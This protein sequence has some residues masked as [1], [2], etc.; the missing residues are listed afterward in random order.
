MNMQAGWLDDLTGWFKGIFQA[1]WNALVDFLHDMVIFV[2]HGVLDLALAIFNAIP[3]PAFITNNGLG[4][5]LGQTGST[6]QWFMGQ[7]KIGDALGLI[8]AGYAFR[9]LRK[10]LTLGQW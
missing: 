3:V 5:L 6:L 8:A 4:T 1:L 10:L 2:V 9:L 7:F